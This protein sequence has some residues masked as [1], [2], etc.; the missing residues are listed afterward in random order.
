MSIMNHSMNRHGF[1]EKLT[2]WRNFCGIDLMRI[3]GT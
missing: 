1:K 3:R 2:D